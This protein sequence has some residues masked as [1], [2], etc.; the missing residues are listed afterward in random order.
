MRLLPAQPPAVKAKP[1]EGETQ[2]AHEYQDVIEPARVPGLDPNRTQSRS[3][4]LTC[5][6]DDCWALA[7]VKSGVVKFQMEPDGKPVL[8]KEEVN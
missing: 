2:E 8:M 7:S 1:D 3:I 5:E 4:R 6:G